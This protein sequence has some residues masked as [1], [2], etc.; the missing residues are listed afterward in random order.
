MS[1]VKR[2]DNYTLEMVAGDDEYVRLNIRDENDVIIQPGV[3]EGA[4][5]GFKRIASDTDFMV[6]QK[7][8]T[9]LIYDEVTQ[10][11][12][13]E[14]HFTSDE[15]LDILGYDG[16]QRT[17]LSCV[18]DIEYQKTILTEVTRTTLLGGTL[19]IKRSI[20]GAV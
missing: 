14:F 18:Y 20:S 19:K 3:G 7:T 13:I 1:I 9:M 8:A 6:T 5:I 4:V 10:P 12:T 2:N 15:T 16:K 17:R 11:Y